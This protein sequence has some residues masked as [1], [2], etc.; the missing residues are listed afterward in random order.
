MENTLSA[1]RLQGAVPSPEPRSLT[2]TSLRS[3]PN[4]WDNV[5]KV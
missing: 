5:F 1:A 3:H 4:K 2:G